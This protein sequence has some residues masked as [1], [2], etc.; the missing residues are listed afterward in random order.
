MLI[1]TKFEFMTFYYLAA[2]TFTSNSQS[3]QSYVNWSG[4][5]QLREVISF[6]DMLCPPIIQKLIEED[7]H[8]NL[9]EDF[10]IDLFTDLDYLLNRTADIESCNILA[11][12]HSPKKE[13]SHDLLDE[14][15]EFAGYDL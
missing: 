4:L 9:Q 3:W 6:D 7:W 13:V 5:T 14:R 11:L 10:Y 15:F 1:S 12:M 8:Y 2:E